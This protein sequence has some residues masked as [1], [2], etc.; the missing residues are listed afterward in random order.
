ME[1][2]YTLLQQYS[3]LYPEKLLFDGVTIMLEFNVTSVFAFVGLLDILHAGCNDLTE[4]F[5][6]V[7]NFIFKRMIICKSLLAHLGLLSKNNILGLDFLEDLFV[8][9]GQFIDV[10]DE[11]TYTVSQENALFVILRNIH[12][13]IQRR[14][15]TNLVS[16]YRFDV[17]ISENGQYPIDI[18]HNDIKELLRP[19]WSLNRHKYYP[20]YS[21]IFITILLL[22]ETTIISILPRE[23]IYLI[24]AHIT[25]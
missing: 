6:D 16:I 8:I 7:A 3:A 17:N 14:L 22:R 4:L 11:E 24:F 2:N 10:Y 15:I 21:T 9:R 23:I 12:G 5:H 1:Y 18:C 13:P 25:N 20:Q 19:T